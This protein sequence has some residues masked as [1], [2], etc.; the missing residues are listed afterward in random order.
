MAA[1]PALY[2]ICDGCEGAYLLTG[3]D[4]C[5]ECGTHTGCCEHA[6]LVCACD[7]SNDDVRARVW[8]WSDCPKPG[9]EEG[10]AVVTCAACALTS[11]DCDEPWRPVT[12]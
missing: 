12:A 5:T 3:A 1:D 8:T 11:S 6:P 9:H 10:C 2:G 7:T 4:H